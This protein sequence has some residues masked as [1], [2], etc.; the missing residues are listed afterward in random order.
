MICVIGS[1]NMD[2]VINTKRIPA[3]GETVMGN[4][5]K[6][7]GG[8]KG[9]NQAVAAARAGAKTSMI[10]SVGSDDFAKVL[11]QNLA[12]SQVDTRFIQQLP[13]QSTGVAL[14]SV[15]EDGSNSIIV[16]PE[17]NYQLT[18]E[19]IQKNIQAIQEAQILLLQHEIPHEV[20]S[21]AIEK[22][23]SLGKTIVLN[24]APAMEI[25]PE[26]YSK[27]DFLVPNEH[28][29][30][31]IYPHKN[32]GKSFD[33]M[34]AFFI[35]HG[36]KNL[37]LT[38]GEQGCRHYDQHG[39]TS[40]PAFKVKASDST[41]AGDTFVGAFAAY[42]SKYNNIPRAIEFGMMAA[43]ISVTRRGAQT[44]IPTLAEMKAVMGDVYTK[45]VEEETQAK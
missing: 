11:L 5:F 19:D 3:P 38:L 30:E 37:I 20:T 4:D 25:H 31:Y 33:E 41:A 17:A 29:L 9:A 42:Y 45:L 28:E 15:G 7:I 13:G 40:Y 16:S 24:P 1:L 26:L 12:D 22:G 10:G 6:T 27:I 35:Q 23:K 39:A 14:I 43:A 8:G 44:S 21:F 18:T 2:L 34:A 36:V 32:S